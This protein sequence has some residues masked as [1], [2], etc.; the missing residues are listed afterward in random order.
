MAKG[1]KT[2]GRN[3]G[4]PNKT[5]KEVRETLKTILLHEIEQLPDLL[6]QIEDP[7]KRVSLSIRLLPYIMPTATEVDENT[8]TE[9]TNLFFPSEPEDRLK[10][11]KCNPFV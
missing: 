10:V 11:L 1:I 6:A 7:E 5:T 2:G 8:L 4:T 9:R 3:K